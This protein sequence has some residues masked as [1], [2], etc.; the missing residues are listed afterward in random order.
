MGKKH[1]VPYRV[2]RPS[3]RDGVGGGGGRWCIRAKETL[4]NGHV[5]LHP[6]LVSG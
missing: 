4:P 5:L 2:Q 3:V 6:A 1:A